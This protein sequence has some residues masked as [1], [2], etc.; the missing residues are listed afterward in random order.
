MTR[1]EYVKKYNYILD[2]S[3]TPQYELQKLTEKYISE[4]EEKNKELIENSE[5]FTKTFLDLKLETEK[6]EFVL[7]LATAL[8]STDRTYSVE[9]IVT[10]IKNLS[11][12][13]KSAINSY[14]EVKETA[15][16][17]L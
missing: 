3:Y 6:N 7:H 8:V 2:R 16:K 15:N 11:L 4:L 5:K 14:Y 17:S 12:K 9:E 10:E 1:E 13:I